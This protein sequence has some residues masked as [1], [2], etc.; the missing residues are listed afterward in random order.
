MEYYRVSYTIDVDAENPKDA[1]LQVEK[2]LNNMDYRPYLTVECPPDGK[3]VS[4]DLE[5]DVIREY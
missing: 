3:K 4:V 5:E 1:A 2:I